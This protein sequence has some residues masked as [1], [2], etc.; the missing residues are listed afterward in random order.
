MSKKQKPVQS[1]KP[2]TPPD[3]S[4]RT[5][6]LLGGGALVAAVA[7]AGAYS[8]GWFDEPKPTSFASEAVRSTGK[9]LA[10]V[11]LA[12]TAENALRA[13]DELLTHYARD[14]AN[15]SALI[16][17]VRGM[18]RG[19]KLNDGTSAVT[20]LCNKYAFD[21]EVNG[22][23]YVYFSRD[24]E[25]H[26]NSF[27][28][29]FLEAGVSLEQRVTANG[30]AQTLRDVIEGGKQLFRADAADVYKFD[31]RQFR[32]D[33]VSMLTHGRGELLHEHLPWSL[34]AFS[35]LMKPAEA[36]WTNAYGE[37]I[38]LV[39]VLD[40]ALAEYETTCALGQAALQRGEVAP[41]E[42]RTR[43]KDYSCFG[44]HSV[45]GFLACWQKG[46]TGNRL[47]ERMAQ[48]M[49]FVTYRLQADALASDVEYDEADAQA[50]QKAPV[51]VMTAFKL[52]ARLKLLGHAF[53]SIN[54]AKK[55]SLMTF[56]AAQENRI[57]AG[58]QA[59]Y[60][61]VVGLRALDWASLRKMPG[62]KFI[63]DVVIALGHA[64]RGMK[65][66]TPQNPDGLA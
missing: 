37:K 35:H 4:R 52:R 45:Y 15:A 63:S 14:L 42:F 11:T 65:L 26:E 9:N 61:S 21:K 41:K 13:A 1:V 49:D 50:Q 6:L 22:K 46:F 19:F 31:D 53:E 32:F 60:E 40:R 64:A 56:S 30:K 18:G 39:T 59:L 20:H 2:E 16:H 33:P 25:V 44:L 12:A 62:E 66:L 8:A 43:I 23:R 54:F 55:H 17:A 57:Q 3:K 48:V 10:P 5:M 29:T 47:P 28:K 51:Q 34:I 58:E 38:D 27:L 7:G 36:Q 24:A